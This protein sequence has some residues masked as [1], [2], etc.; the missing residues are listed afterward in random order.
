MTLY[1]Q[2]LEDLKKLTT[3][4]DEAL[5]AA[6]EHRS[7]REIRFC[8]ASVRTYQENAQLALRDIL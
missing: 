4:A 3:W 7:P 5:Q 8:L 1:E 2:L 6:E